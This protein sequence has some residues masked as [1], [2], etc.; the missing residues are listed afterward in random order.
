[1]VYLAKLKARNTIIFLS[2]LEAE[3]LIITR[4]SFEK[5]YIQYWERM[6]H[7]CIKTSQDEEV[8]KGIVQEIFKSLWERREDLQLKEVER[9]LI[10]AVKL[11]TFEYIRN[12][13]TKQQHHEN[14]LHN[15][16]AHYIEDKMAERELSSKINHLVDNLP[17]QCKNVFK[18]SREEGMTNKQ[19][20]HQLLISERAVEYHISKALHTLRTHLADYIVK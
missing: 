10:R 11:K 8:A 12:K 16:S 2:P 4:E 7:F 18:M 5:L 14:I 17:K 6:Y 19:I 13:V 1:M 20:A 3:V 15:A 9:Y